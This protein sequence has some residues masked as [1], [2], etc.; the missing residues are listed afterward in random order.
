MAELTRRFSLD[1]PLNIK[2]K[3]LLNDKSMQLQEQKEVEHFMDTFWEKV[4]HLKI[5]MAQLE[6]FYCC[7]ETA[8]LN[9]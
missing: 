7:M 5:C 4:K 3:L 1:M 8:L 2:P 6:D 9:W